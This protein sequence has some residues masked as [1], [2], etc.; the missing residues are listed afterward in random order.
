MTGSHEV[1]GSIPI[2]ST[3][4]NKGL[5]EYP[6]NLFGF[7]GKGA[8]TRRYAPPSRG[9][10]RP[11][12]ALRATLEGSKAP[13]PGATRHPLPE[14]EGPAAGHASQGRQPAGAP[15]GRYGRGK[16]VVAVRQD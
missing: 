12:P 4:K 5:R 2:S 7:D 8:L 13:S 6:A 11:H 10:R 3:I 15:V 16:H 1:I 9:Q 14:G